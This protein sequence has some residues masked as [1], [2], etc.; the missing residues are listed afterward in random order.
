[1]HLR[2]AVLVAVV[3]AALVSGASASE[4]MKRSECPVQDPLGGEGA[5]LTVHHMS[6]GKARK[7]VLAFYRVSQSQG[8]HAT[9]HGFDCDAKSGSGFPIVKCRRGEKRLRYEGGFYK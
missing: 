3:A 7:I 4:P 8:P 6:C 5:S 1:M 2:A 9:V